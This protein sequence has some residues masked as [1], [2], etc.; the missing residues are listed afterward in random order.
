MTNLCISDCYRECSKQFPCNYLFNCHQSSVREWTY[1][2]GLVTSCH[3]YVFAQ[4]INMSMMTWNVDIG[5]ITVVSQWLRLFTWYPS[6]ILLFI[7]VFESDILG[8]KCVSYKF[9]S[10]YVTPLVLCMPFVYKMEP[11]GLLFFL[12]IINIHLV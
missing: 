4:V 1:H 10:V 3:R 2:N 12:S 5:L 7:V 6:R 8:C 11:C 9:Q